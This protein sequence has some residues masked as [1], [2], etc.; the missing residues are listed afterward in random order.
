MTDFRTHWRPH[1]VRM[2]PPPRSPLEILQEAI[3]SG[4]VG[5]K[6]GSQIFCL[7]CRPQAQVKHAINHA[8]LADG[9]RCRDCARVYGNG[10][11]T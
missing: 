6:V 11:W 7:D 4:V 5:S 10:E 2:T 8:A 9:A 3:D 1:G